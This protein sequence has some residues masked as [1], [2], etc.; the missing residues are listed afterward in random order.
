MKKRRAVVRMVFCMNRNNQENGVALPETDICQHANFVGDKTQEPAATL[1]QKRSVGLD[2]LGFAESSRVHGNLVTFLGANHEQ[3]SEPA[4]LAQMAL[5]V[6]KEIVTLLSLVSEVVFGHFAE[7]REAKHSQGT[8]Q[9]GDRATARLDCTLE[10]LAVDILHILKQGD[11]RIFLGS[12]CN[13]TCLSQHVLLAARLEFHFVHEVL[14]AGLVENAVRID[15]E[16]KEVVIALEIL[17]ID[18]VDELEGSL[19]AMALATMGK[20][21]DGDTA[22]AIDDINRL[23]VRVK[24]KRYTELLNGIQVQFRLLGLPSKDKKMCRQEG[25]YSQSTSESQVRSRI[26]G[27]S[28]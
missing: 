6:I 3:M 14:D 21:G 5:A 26:S 25:G 23:G 13:D 12:G 18:L 15:E 20:A 17:G 11:E 9:A 24:S 2:S 1:L 16:Y 19:L 27:I 28:L 8:R 7:S 4:I 22:A 10:K